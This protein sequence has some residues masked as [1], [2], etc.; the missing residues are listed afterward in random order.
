M[1][2]DERQDLYRVGE[3]LGVDKDDID[4]WLVADVK[5]DDLPEDDLSGQTVCFTGTSRCSLQGKPL[6]GQQKAQLATNAG[7]S[8]V[9]S[10]TKKLNI[11]VVADP[12]TQSGKA[13]KAR[14]YGVRIISERAFWQKLG[15]NI[16]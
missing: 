2:Q 9:K 16:E 14:N 11:L 7:L 3:L 15:V 12:D 13:K 1:A 8:P 5:I 4:N 10:V 6:D